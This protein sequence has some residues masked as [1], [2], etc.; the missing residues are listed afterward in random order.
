MEDEWAIVRTTEGI[1]VLKVDWWA[2]AP[3]IWEILARG[4]KTDQEAIFYLPLYNDRS[5]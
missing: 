1:V 5:E 3:A 2:I 4:F